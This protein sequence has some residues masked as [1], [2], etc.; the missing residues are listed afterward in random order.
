MKSVL[1]RSCGAVVGAAVLV[2]S[3]SG[4]AS[5]QMGGG[6]AEL[7]DAKG[8][9]VGTATLTD[10]PN[11]VLIH[12]MLTS[13][14]AGTH[15][16]HVHAVGK[17][18]APGFTSAGGHFNPAG[19]PHGIEVKG[20]GH[21]GDLPNIHVPA[22]GKLDVEILARGTTLSGGS[23]A[24]MDADGGALVIHATGDDYKTDPSGAAGDRLACGVVMK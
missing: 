7:K 2:W 18:E 14:P 22:D 11:G 24:I 5:A 4:A 1:M 17:C 8:A 21:A 12:L 20:G 6:K 23:N 16:F 13:G 9:T 19:V 15:A 10:T 3:M